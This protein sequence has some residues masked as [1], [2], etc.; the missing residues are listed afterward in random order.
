M[1]SILPD[2]S[3]A[4]AI[5]FRTTAADERTATTANVNR[6]EMDFD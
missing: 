1:S 4:A 6:I 3:H 2:E 5:R